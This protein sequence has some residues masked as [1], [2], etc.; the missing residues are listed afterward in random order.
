MGV[1]ERIKEMKIRERESSRMKI[2]E[3]ENKKISFCSN[4]SGHFS[5]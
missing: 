2:E 3:R 5:I 4:L 1:G